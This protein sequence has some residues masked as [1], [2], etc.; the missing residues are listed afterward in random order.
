MVYLSTVNKLKLTKSEYSLVYEMGTISTIIYN[1]ALTLVQ[2]Y[3]HETGLY[4]RFTDLYHTIKQF[5]PYKQLP[6][7]VSQK[8]IRNLD[9]DMKS[10]FKKM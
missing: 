4:L 6:A 10:F 1:Q 3:Y 7:S 9:S 2:N 5:P 8:I